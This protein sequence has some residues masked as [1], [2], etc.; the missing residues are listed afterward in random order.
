M[1]A[2]N[3]PLVAQKRADQLGVKHQRAKKDTEWRVFGPAT[4]FLR[5]LLL[6]FDARRARQSLSPSLKLTLRSSL[7]TSTANLR[8]FNPNLLS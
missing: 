6:T 2:R 7:S 1:T 8:I 3:G 5:C 4:F